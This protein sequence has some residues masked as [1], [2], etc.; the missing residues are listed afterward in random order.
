MRLSCAATRAFRSA[1]HSGQTSLPRCA[2]DSQTLASVPYEPDPSAPWMHLAMVVDG[3][4]LLL[5]RDAD[6][7][8]VGMGATVEYQDAPLFVGADQ[9]GGDEV[10][11]Y[12]IGDL[13]ELKVFSRPLAPAEVAMLA[14]G[15][16]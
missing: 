13:D 16:A 14:A 4:S 12:F 15:D 10:N 11:D 1:T 6:L 9:D 5:Y 8:A 7:V 3:A 2:F